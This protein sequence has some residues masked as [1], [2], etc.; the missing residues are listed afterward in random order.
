MIG[1]SAIVISCCFKSYICTRDPFQRVRTQSEI[2]NLDLFKNYYI[3]KYHVIFK[4]QGMNRILNPFVNADV[5]SVIGI[6]A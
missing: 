4:P 2:P 3:R 1:S 5:V 6:T